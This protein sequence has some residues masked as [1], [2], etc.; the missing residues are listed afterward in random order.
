M[1][2]KPELQQRMC[3]GNKLQAGRCASWKMT[4]ETPEVR[5]DKRKQGEERE[6]EREKDKKKREK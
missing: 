3:K 6:K 2:C 1:V 5:S 4:G